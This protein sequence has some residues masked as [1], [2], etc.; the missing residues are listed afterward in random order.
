YPPQKDRG[1]ANCG[2][3]LRLPAR[4]ISGS[5]QKYRGGRRRILRDRRVVARAS[6]PWHAAPR[7]RHRVRN[8]LLPFRNNRDTYRLDTYDRRVGKLPAAD[9][10][11]PYVSSLIPRAAT[12]DGHVRRCRSRSCRITPVTR[13]RPRPPPEPHGRVAVEYRSER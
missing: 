12:L 6:V 9:A 5:R 10:R 2:C 4:Q 7:G 8:T 1:P 13:R 3:V 11:R